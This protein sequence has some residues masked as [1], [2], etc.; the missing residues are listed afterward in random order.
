M[1][2]CVDNRFAKNGPVYGI[3]S[4]QDFFDFFV[5]SKNNKTNLK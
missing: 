2:C 3:K 5:E 1:A 4:Q